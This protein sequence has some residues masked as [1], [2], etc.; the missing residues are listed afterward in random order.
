MEGPGLYTSGENIFGWTQCHKTLS[1]PRIQIQIAN[2]T[3]KTLKNAET[4]ALNGNLIIVWSTCC[5]LWPRIQ[6]EKKF[7]PPQWLFFPLLTFLFFF[8]KV[9]FN[10]SDFDAAS[11][12]SHGTSFTVAGVCSVCRWFAWEFSVMYRSQYT[13]LPR[14]YNSLNPI[15]TPIANRPI[16]HTLSISHILIPFPW[17]NWLAMKGGMGSISVCLFWVLVL[18]VNSVDLEEVTLFIFNF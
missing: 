5:Y 2:S 7:P 16:V 10:N 1:I 17:L 13:K 6:I 8:H 14:F 12:E 18:V 4:S 9:F 3:S 15:A 11:W